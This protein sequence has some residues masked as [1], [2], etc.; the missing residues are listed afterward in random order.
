M[1]EK[2]KNINENTAKM[3]KKEKD[4]YMEYVLG[5]VEIYKQQGGKS[6]DTFHGTQAS[7]ADRGAGAGSVAPLGRAGRLRRAR[8]LAHHH[9]AQG[10]HR[11]GGQRRH[12]EQLRRLLHDPVV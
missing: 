10:N 7:G 8:H 1:K 2:E 12:R 5:W 11:H 9:R 6:H 4:E 3:L